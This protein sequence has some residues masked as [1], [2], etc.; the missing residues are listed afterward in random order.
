M[1]KRQSAVRTKGKPKR[2]IMDPNKRML[3]RQLLIGLAI[4]SLVGLIVAG[5][6]Y[7]TRITSLT[8]TEVTATGGETI[9]HAVVASA[10]A[11]KLDGKYFGLIPHR[12]A[13]WY[14][15]RDMYAALRQI[16][17]IK[18][19]VI[20]RVSGTALTVT[21][22]EYVPY[23]LWCADRESESCLFIDKTGYAFG[24]APKLSG[25]SFVR[26]RSLGREM[27]IGGTVASSS[28]LATMAE[29]IELV[30][31]G[32]RFE[33]ATVETDTAGDVFYIVAGGGEFKASFRD[34]A[35]HVYDNLQTI[36][37][38]AEFKD[39]QPGT[40]Q[41]IDLRFG[42]K[43]FVNEEMGGEASS[44]DDVM[45]TSTTLSDSTASSTR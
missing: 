30:K 6:W 23:A 10:V 34:S 26:Y 32:N 39:I 44:T 25:G 29:F 5:L 4:F 3:V 16:P 43:V 45:G 40:F 14:P 7:G 21:F 33:I 13:W 18:D 11:A 24:A 28:S 37:N 9:D 31:S 41:Y 1:F 35:K 2:R 27:A 8:L 19:P 20:A 38:S 36:V 17:R 12:F 42:N 22:D 15:E